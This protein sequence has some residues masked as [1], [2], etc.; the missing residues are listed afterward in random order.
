MTY[1]YQFKDNANAEAA[2]HARSLL[3]D[4]LQKRAELSTMLRKSYIRTDNDDTIGAAI[5]QLFAGGIAEVHGDRADG[6]ALMVVGETGVGKTHALKRQ[7][8]LREEFQPYETEFGTMMPLV[9]FE[10]PSPCILKEFGREFL[11]AMDYPVPKQLARHLVWEKVRE[12]VEAR[13]VMLVHVDEMQHVFEGAKLE[14][15][16]LLTNTLKNIMQ[17]SAWPVRFIFSGLPSL[18]DFKLEDDQIWWR[19]RIVKLR[20]LDFANDVELVRHVVNL[21]HEKANLDVSHLQGNDFLARLT[22][23]VRGALG[24]MIEFTIETALDVLCADYS[25]KILTVQDF[26]NTYRSYAG[27]SDEENVFLA[28]RWYDISPFLPKKAE[29]EDEALK[30]FRRKKKS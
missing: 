6:R 18:A 23:A 3:S 25:M 17:Q 4:A 21:M 11:R 12:Q 19:T 28:E 13:R 16:S 29:V 30:R 26:A 15:I 8:R 2:A 1:E 10:A 14:D 20:T 24:R 27:C 9:S 7:F 22:H 5:D